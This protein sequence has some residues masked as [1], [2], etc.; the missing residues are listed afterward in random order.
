[1]HNLLWQAGSSWQAGLLWQ[2]G[3]PRVG[4]R[5]SPNKVDAVFQAYR[6]GWFWGRF[7]AQ[8]GASPLTTGSL[9]TTT[10]LLTTR[11]LLT[12]GSVL[13]TENPFTTESTLPADWVSH[14]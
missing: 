5:S 2:A 4:L 7:A 12:K 9:L 11:S 6:V 8:R 1:M 3:L 14:A 10:S 13:T